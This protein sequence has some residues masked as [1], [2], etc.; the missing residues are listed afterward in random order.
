MFLL[1]DLRSATVLMAL[2]ASDGPE[3]TPLFLLFQ[4]WIQ[5]SMADKSSGRLEATHLLH[6]YFSP[7]RN[8]R[9]LRSQIQV[10]S[11]TR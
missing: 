8:S 6:L 3:L 5:R 1:E 7:P 9:L 11:C 10:Q 2:V 4:R